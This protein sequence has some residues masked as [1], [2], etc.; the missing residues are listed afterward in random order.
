MGRS[1]P[2]QETTQKLREFQEAG[3][4]IEVVRGDVARE[5][6]VAQVLSQIKANLRPLRGIFHCAGIVADGVLSQ[7]NWGR[8]TEVMSPKVA[9]AWNLHQLTRGLPLDFF[10]MFSSVVSVL[11]SAGQAN[12]ASAC[13]FEDGLAH[14]RRGRGL[15][16]LSINWGPWSTVGAVVKHHVGDRLKS[17][18]ILTVSP[19]EGLQVMERL[20][21]CDHVQAVVLRAD[22]R[23]F[24]GQYPAERRPSILSELLIGVQPQTKAPVRLQEPVLLSQIEQA[25]P[26]ERRKLLQTH[27]RQVVIQVLGLEPSFFIDPQQGLRDIGIDSLM[28]LELRNRLQH[29]TGQ[30]LPSTLAFDFPTLDAMVNYLAGRM[31]TQKSVPDIHVSQRPDS[32]TSNAAG[33][34]NLSDEEA[35]ALL[36]EE[37]SKGK[38]GAS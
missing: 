21:S 24:L 27:I 8:F 32:H 14:Y 23:R 18:G 10:V 28:S 1:A 13:A 7:Q 12:H 2:S 4:Q 25:S 35:E 26:H 30:S 17:R 31:W 16:A 15:P 29:S 6:N 5:D 34:G 9:G 36:V 20:M 19:E 11:G 37:L 3:A 33:L 38:S 22:W